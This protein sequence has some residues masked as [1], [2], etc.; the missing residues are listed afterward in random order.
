MNP[1]SF[2][3]VRAMTDEE[4]RIK[5]GELCGKR[6]YR[7]CPTDDE[8]DYEVLKHAFSHFDPAW[9]CRKCDAIKFSSE[10]AWRRDI[11]EHEFPNYPKDLNAV[12]EAVDTLPENKVRGFTYNLFKL[13]AGTATKLFFNEVVETPWVTAFNVINATAR[14]RAEAFVLTMQNL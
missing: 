14:Q 2:D 6:I 11:D 8:H 3:T 10:R 12:R 13:M 9:R 1:T 5:V 7:F 4:L